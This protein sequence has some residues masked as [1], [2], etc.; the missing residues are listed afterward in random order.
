MYAKSEYI[1]VFTLYLTLTS[2][3][4][5]KALTALN[6]YFLYN[7]IKDKKLPVTKDSNIT[8]MKNDFKTTSKPLMSFMGEFWK[9]RY[10]F[11]AATYSLGLFKHPEISALIEKGYTMDPFRFIVTHV[12][13]ITSP[14]VFTVPS[15]A[16]GIG[17]HGGET[18]VKYYE[19]LEQAI[20]RY[21]Y[22]VANNAWEYPQ[23]YYQKGSIDIEL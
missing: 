21:Q 12:D 1:R 20:Q 7:M 9:L 16:V 8:I 23:E 5:N 2:L 4:F 11:Q 14:M 3:Y 19:G 17:L 18:S 13:C 6:I 22:A 10:D 15:K